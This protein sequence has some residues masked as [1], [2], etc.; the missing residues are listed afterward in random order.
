MTAQALIKE[1]RTNE[2]KE[3][4]TYCKIPKPVPVPASAF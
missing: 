2:K 4:Q 1:N 3:Q